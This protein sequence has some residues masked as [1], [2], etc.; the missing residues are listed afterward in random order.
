M[1]QSGPDDRAN[2]NKK[3][4]RVEVA[5]VSFFLIKNLFDEETRDGEAHG[6]EKP[7]PTRL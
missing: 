6:K 5:N 7:I 3:Q 4:K 2:D 1:P